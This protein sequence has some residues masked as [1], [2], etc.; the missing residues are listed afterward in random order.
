[1]NLLAK[2][3][4]NKLQEDIHLKN[5][6][7]E[8]DKYSFER[9]LKGDLGEQIKKELKNPPKNN[10]FLGIKLKFERW[11]LKKQE[12]REYRKTIKE[13]HKINK[14]IEKEMGGLK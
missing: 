12:Y 6:A 7:V 9:Q 4:Y 2:K 11:R 1:M 10:W 14:I 8:S 3:E 5:I 13:L